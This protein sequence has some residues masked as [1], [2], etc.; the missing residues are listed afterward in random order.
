MNDSKEVVGY[1]YTE[2]D[3]DIYIQSQMQYYHEFDIHF[4]KNVYTGEARKARSCS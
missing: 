3:A 2:S 1:E 4:Q